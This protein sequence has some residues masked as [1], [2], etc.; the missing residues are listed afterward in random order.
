MT[1]KKAQFQI[2]GLLKLKRVGDYL[3]L[4]DKKIKLVF[5]EKDSALNTKCFLHADVAD[6][7][8]T[9]THLVLRNVHIRRYIFFSTKIERCIVP[10]DNISTIQ[11]LAK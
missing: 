10:I 2:E 7:S 6:L 3:N 11:I 5:K 9:G 8:D 4:V 1:D